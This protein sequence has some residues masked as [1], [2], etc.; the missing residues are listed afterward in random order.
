[1]TFSDG[2][3]RIESRGLSSGGD[4]EVD[5]NRITMTDKWGAMACQAVRPGE[6]KETYETSTFSWSATGRT[7]R[8]RPT[9]SGDELR[10]PNDCV[11]RTFLLTRQ[12]WKRQGT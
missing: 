5:G 7:L 12:P 4:Y 1:M 9:K 2:H 8:L 10:Y 3:Y 6:K 11:G